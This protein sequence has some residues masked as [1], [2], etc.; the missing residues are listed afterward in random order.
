M[1]GGWE[2]GKKGVKWKKR[3]GQGEGR[4]RGLQQWVAMKGKEERVKCKRRVHI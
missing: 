4:G 3:K 2:S 1:K